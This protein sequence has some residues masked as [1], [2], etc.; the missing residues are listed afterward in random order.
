MVA[1]NYDGLKKWERDG[2]MKIVLRVDSEAEMR[3]STLSHIQSNT[4]FV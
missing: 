3:T 1:Q 4:I 2:E